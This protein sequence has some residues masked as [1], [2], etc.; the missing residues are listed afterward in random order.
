MKRNVRT[1]IMISGTVLFLLAVFSYPQKSYANPP[2]SVTVSYDSGSQN[3]TVTI[4]HKSSS[5]GFHYIKYVEI[6]KNGIVVSNNTYIISL[7][8]KHLLIHISYLPLKV[9]GWK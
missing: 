6:K 5:T 9:I 3:L 1:I 8:R 2:Q 7:T 4:S